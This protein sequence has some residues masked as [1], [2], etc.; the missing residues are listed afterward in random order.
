MLISYSKSAKPNGL[1]IHP[2]YY[3]EFNIDVFN[4]AIVLA[5][6]CG[7]FLLLLFSS[8]RTRSYTYLEICVCSSGS[9]RRVILIIYY[10]LSQY[11]FRL[12]L[13]VKNSE[14]KDQLDFD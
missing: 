13:R 6:R 2:V 3:L 7:C 14:P 9:N 1:L 5:I 12:Q 11:A 10:C 8:T 4:I